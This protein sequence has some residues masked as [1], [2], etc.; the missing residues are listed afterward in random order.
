MNEK[1]ILKFNLQSKD[2]KIANVLNQDFLVVEIYA[3]SDICPN[4]NGSCFTL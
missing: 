1:K 2:L 3:I 4:L